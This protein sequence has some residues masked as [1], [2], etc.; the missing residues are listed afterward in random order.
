MVALVWPHSSIEVRVASNHSVLPSSHISFVPCYGS[1]LLSLPLGGYAAIIVCTF[2]LW[3]LWP[4]LGKMLPG[5]KLSAQDVRFFCIDFKVGIATLLENPSRLSRDVQGQS[6]W[7]QA[8]LKRCRGGPWGKLIHSLG[9]PFALTNCLSWESVVSIFNSC[10]RS[11]PKK[12]GWWHR[13]WMRLNPILMV[14]L[15][16]LRSR[17]VA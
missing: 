17:A 6:I 1:V 2:L 4:S 9:I 15:P 11:G 7:F 16:L 5:I 8:C 14:Y 12:E 13:F 10:G 3:A